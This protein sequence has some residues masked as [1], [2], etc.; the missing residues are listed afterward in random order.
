MTAMA[1]PS[2]FLQVALL[3]VLLAAATG[4]APS[5]PSGNSSPSLHVALAADPVPAHGKSPD[6]IPASSAGQ[7]QHRAL[8]GILGEMEESALTLPRVM[9]GMLESALSSLD[10]VSGGFLSG[11]ATSHVEF[12]HSDDG[13]KLVVRVHMPQGKGEDG[14]SAPRTLHVSV[15]GQSHL[16]I[17]MEIT[18]G[19]FRSKAAHTVA[20]PAR[21]SK[22]GIDISPQSDGSVHISLNVLK[23]KDG[24]QEGLN[25]LGNRREADA[26]GLFGM[27]R[28]M[29]PAL[30]ERLAGTV[31]EGGQERTQEVPSSEI[32]ESCNRDHLN[33]HLLAKKCICDGTGDGES[34]AVCFG[35]L[36]SKSVSMARRL[37]LNDIAT[38]TKHVAI[39]CASGRE[40]K[41]ACLEKVSTD[42]IKYIY[43]R[44]EPGSNL[45]DRIRQAIESEDDGPS[46]FEASSSLYVAKV[47]LVVLFLMLVFWIG[48][49]CVYRRNGGVGGSI[50]SQYLSSILSQGTQ[51]RAD[52]SHSVG[53]IGRVRMGRN[54]K[55]GP[56]AIGKVA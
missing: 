37:G 22:D 16:R 39:E 49:I 32:I 21:V 9:D 53:S 3:F 8:R 7:R 12:A 24:E 20:L 47:V 41:V 10:Q 30:F 17:T 6:G 51:S 25:V 5:L 13:T 54:G 36:I 4:E 2:P 14:K 42:I 44:K 50:D 34:R 28:S 23:D 19:N 48:A 29:F 11:Y 55:T 27:P 15:V 40:D 33:Q 45:T 31:D 43:E 35:S 18:S 56:T 52:R 1:F 38:S 26:D 46:Q